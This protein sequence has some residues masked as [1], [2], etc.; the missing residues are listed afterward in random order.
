MPAG[1]AGE[2]VAAQLA[3]ARRYGGAGIVPSGAYHLESHLESPTT[4]PDRG[5]QCHELTA[6]AASGAA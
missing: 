3:V 6:A 1:H 5:V 2:D 4:V